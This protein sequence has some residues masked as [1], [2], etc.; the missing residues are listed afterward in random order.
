MVPR[1]TSCHDD[2]YDRLCEL[3]AELGLMPAT[4]DAAD[5]EWHRR[6]NKK[7]DYWLA[8]SHRFDLATDRTPYTA[9][10]AV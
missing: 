6:H 2:R 5:I 3:T 9:H 10:G 7:A 4:T 1:R 8:R